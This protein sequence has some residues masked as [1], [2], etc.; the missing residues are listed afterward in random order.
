M[1]VCPVWEC[2]WRGCRL[3]KGTED[4]I[5]FTREDVSQHLVVVILFAEIFI[6]IASA[7]LLTDSDSADHVH[8]MNDNIELNWQNSSIK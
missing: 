6:E 5:R 1:F 7:L 2:E 8:I 4:R 3:W